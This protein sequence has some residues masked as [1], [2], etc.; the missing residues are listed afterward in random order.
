[1]LK[2]ILQKAVA[3]QSRNLNLVGVIKTYEDFTEVIAT[4]PN[5]SQE[6]YLQ[7]SNIKCHDAL[8]IALDNGLL[9]NNVT[10][11]S[12]RNSNIGDYPEILKVLARSVI[13]SQVST[14]SLD[15]NNIDDQK[16]TVL[17]NRPLA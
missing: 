14:L 9:G 10:N 11:F 3:D 16:L 8:L 7:L 12:L 13:K 5:L 17:V 2:E 1:M 15:G 6:V 4:L